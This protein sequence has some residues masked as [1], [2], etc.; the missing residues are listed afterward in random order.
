MWWFKRAKPATTITSCVY[1]CLG[2][3]CPKWVTLNNNYRDEKTKEM[4]PR[5]E[6]RCWSAW[7]PILLIE[8]REQL[9]ALKK[10]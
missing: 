6:G 10:E 8:I 1:H 7:V 2:K 3:D 9:K 5:L 4:T